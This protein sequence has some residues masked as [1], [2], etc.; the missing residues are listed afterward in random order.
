MIRNLI[1][2]LLWLVVVFLIIRADFI[3]HALDI[4]IGAVRALIVLAGV[5]S[6]IVAFSDAKQVLAQ[7]LGRARG[8]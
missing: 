5:V 3:A 6:A 4:E 1:Y 7:I 2:L 8:K